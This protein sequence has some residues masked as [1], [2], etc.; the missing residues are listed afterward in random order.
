MTKKGFILIQIIVY[1]H[2][3]L[4]IINIYLPNYFDITGTE[5][6]IKALAPFA[7]FFRLIVPIIFITQF[8]HRSIYKHLGLFLIAVGVLSLIVPYTF[9]TSV[10]YYLGFATTVI[11]VLGLLVFALIAFTKEQENILGIYL[12]ALAVFY[13]FTSSIIM[14]LIISL[15]LSNLTQM[16][17]TI[18]IPV[19]LYYVAFAL[20]LYIVVKESKESV[21]GD[22]GLI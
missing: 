4:T 18:A 7:F 12:A 17:V 13:A 5:E 9:E 10:Y 20:L 19:L 11:N 6:H 2:L 22:K 21:A 16:I 3:L 8:H 1:G 15:D 14:S